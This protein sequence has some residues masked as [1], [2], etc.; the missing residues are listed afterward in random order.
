MI[1]ITYWEL[2]EGMSVR[3]RQEV[4]TTL[5]ESGTFPPENVEIL[6]WDSTPDGWGILVTEA[7]SA[8]DVAR[9]VNMWRAPAAGFFETTRTAPAQPVQDVLEQTEELL[10][11]LPAA[12]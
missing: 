10:A 4:A 11:S 7:E 8:E 1:F 2:N 12:D 3:E 5:V 6:R 9:A